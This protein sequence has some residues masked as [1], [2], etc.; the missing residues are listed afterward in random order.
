MHGGCVQL[1]MTEE[2]LGPGLHP[3]RVFYHKT[4]NL[5]AGDGAQLSSTCLAYVMLSLISSPEK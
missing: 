1:S 4:C 2:L 5:V 3:P